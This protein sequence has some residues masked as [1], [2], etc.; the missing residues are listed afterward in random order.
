MYRQTGNYYHRH[1]RQYHQANSVN[2]DE[3]DLLWGD[4]DDDDDDIEISRK[5]NISHQHGDNS[6]D[7]EVDEKENENSFSSSSMTLLN[8]GGGDDDHDEGDGGGEDEDEVEIGGGNHYATR[9]NDRQDCELRQDYYVEESDDNDDSDNNSNHSSSINSSSSR[10]SSSSSSST[11]SIVSVQS[12]IERIEEFILQAVIEPLTE[13][14]N[15]PS[16]PEIN[17]FNPKTNFKRKLSFHHLTHARSLTSI[18]MVASFCHDLLSQSTN[19]TTDE[20]YS[21]DDDDSDIGNETNCDRY[22]HLNNDENRNDGNSKNC[23]LRSDNADHNHSNRGVDNDNNITNN[24]R[25]R[26][27]R[28]TTTTREVYY[29]YVTHF[30]DQR[31]CDKAI[32][33]LVSILNLP[34][35]QSLG[36][37]ASPKGWFCGSIDVYN[38]R[39]NELKF[40]GRE[41]DTHGMPITPSTYDND[42]ITYYTEGRQRHDDNNRDRRC[43]DSNNNRSSNSSSI[44]SSSNID[45][46]GIIG[47]ESDGIE[48]EYSETRMGDTTIRIESDARCI[49]V[50]EK[51]GVYTRL[52]EDKF[53]LRFLP[54]ILVT[55]KGFP[56]VG[57]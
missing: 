44:P 6:S 20:S 26:L 16:L 13:D 41:L 14:P 28:R 11:S 45:D 46:M 43:C 23:L 33:D 22:H 9:K 50:I 30:R 42:Y 52:S 3:D 25:H 31:E 15:H 12:V 24:R 18:V 49:L 57:K 54:C 35:R 34:S 53:F 1:H 56:D 32:W 21:D 4:G 19:N 39:T 2:N 27:L 29:F 7:E 51:E 10:S 5:Q 40:N 17:A 8:N 47:R 55:G 38:G 48:Y 37:V 36:L